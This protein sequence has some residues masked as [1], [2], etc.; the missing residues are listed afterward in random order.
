M[1]R[2]GGVRG[3]GAAA[4]PRSAMSAKDT[5]IPRDTIAETLGQAALPCATFD[6]GASLAQYR[7]AGSLAESGVLIGLKI[8]IH[9][10]LVW[11]LATQVF[12]VAPLWVSVAVV[13]AALPTG[14]NAYLFAERYGTGI[15]QA[16]TA[17]LVSTGITIGTLSLLLLVLGVR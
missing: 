6:M 10:L 1:A 14:V 9:P 17:V 16:A 15:A 7:I 5:M 8:V 4:R 11:L 12:D 13:M 3:L 2:R